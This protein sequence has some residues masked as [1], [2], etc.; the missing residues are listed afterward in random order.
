MNKKGE[1]TP[2]GIIAG[3]I[4]AVVAF[5]LIFFLVTKII[6]KSDP[7]VEKLACRNSILVRS[8][9]NINL[10]GFNVE[11]FPLLC[12]TQS[13]VE[14]PSTD[15]GKPL[16]MHDVGELLAE[17]WWMFGEGIEKQYFTNIMGGQK[18][19]IC[20][21][22][23]IKETSSFKKGNHI[24]IGE[25]FHYLDV[26]PYTAIGKKKYEFLCND[27]LDNDGD[28][29]IDNG[30]TEDCDNGKSRHNSLCERKGGVCSLRFLAGAATQ[31]VENPDSNYVFFNKWACDEGQCYVPKA[32]VATYMQY[33][34]GKSEEG[35]RGYVALLPTTELTRRS[36][37][38]PGQL[39][40]IAIVS[41]D[42]T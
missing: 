40:G 3:I 16:I 15:D 20:G 30:D 7:L 8:G 34:E 17:C 10:G 39:Y 32:F 22:F 28:K 2:I 21:T 26:T 31:T 11:N 6:E 18:C 19:F 42:Q 9:T 4:L 33:V 25:L 24:E 41:P 37:L 13:G 14:I 12:K 38:T 23:G 36:T 29:K 27:G 5:M 35:G 1:G